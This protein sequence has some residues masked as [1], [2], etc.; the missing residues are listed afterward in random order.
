MMKT[1]THHIQGA[2]EDVDDVKVWEAINIEDKQVAL[3]GTQFVVDDR[4]C[5]S[6]SNQHYR[7]YLNANQHGEID[8]GYGQFRL[9]LGVRYN[10]HCLNSI[11]FFL[12][13][14]PSHEV[15]IPKLSTLLNWI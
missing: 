13:L 11:L 3:S 6:V 5:G 1:T 4:N 10:A 12:H 7:V 15:T 8:T 14:L 2:I 9:N